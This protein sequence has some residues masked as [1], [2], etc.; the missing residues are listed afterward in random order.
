MLNSFQD[1]EIKLD[2]GEKINLKDFFNVYYPLLTIYA[3]K[4]IEDIDV[5]EDIIQD[6]F[7]SFWMKKKSFPNI[8]AIK[9]FLYVS[10]RNACLDYLKHSKVVEKFRITSLSSDENSESVMDEIIRKE[11]YSEIYGEINKLPEMGRKVLLLA[12]RENSNEEIAEILNIAI[13]TVKTHKARAYKVL[14]KSLKEIF[15][16]FFPFHRNLI[17]R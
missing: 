5:R 1:S 15:L 8:F 7:V 4:Y 2:N 12:M 17:R 9:S 14:R 13:T 10:A 11:A 6:V 16:L 3:S